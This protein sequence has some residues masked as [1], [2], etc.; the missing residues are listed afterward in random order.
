VF[1]RILINK[2]L[3][4]IYISLGY[5]D[6]KIEIIAK[7]YNEYKYIRNHANKTTLEPL[8]IKPHRIKK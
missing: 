1:V 6:Y 8:N 4:Q 2:R 3:S 5:K 7:L